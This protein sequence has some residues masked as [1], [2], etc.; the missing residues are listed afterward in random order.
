MYGIVNME[1]RKFLIIFSLIFF[2]IFFLGCTSKNTSSDE[3]NVYSSDYISVSVKLPNSVFVGDSFSIPITLSTQISDNR[4]IFCLHSFK[5]I[6]YEVN[7]KD[8]V[9]SEDV[10]YEKENN[11]YVYKFSLPQNGYI[12]IKD[13]VINKNNEKVV[14][15]GCFKDRV[16]ILF[17]GN[18]KKEG[19]EYL[20][21]TGISRFSPFDVRE[22]TV[23]YDKLKNKYIFII[24]LIYKRNIGNI[25]II[26]ISRSE[27]P[28][29]SVSSVGDKNSLNYIL[30]L[31][32]KDR[33]YTS[34]G[35]FEFPNSKDSLINL[36]VELDFSE[37]V[38]SGIISLILDYN[39][40]AL[41]DAGVISIQ[42]V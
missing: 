36:K 25:D 26:G 1:V 11:Q 4:W 17:S 39:I 41:I 27:I 38:R 37:E 32:Y 29:C 12:N 42:K 35:V 9:S 20:N 28:K 34:S 18:L 24:K 3:K 40:V 14:L 33:T 19:I 13:T 7:G 15:L 23:Y 2:S 5:S 31:V 8:C 10:S 6:S 21:V 22:A 16:N 30:T